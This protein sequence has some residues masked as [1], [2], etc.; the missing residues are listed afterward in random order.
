MVWP[1]ERL[2]S[3]LDSLTRWA[4]PPDSVVRRL[5]QPHVAEADVDQRLHVAGD[6]R[7]VGEELE[8]LLA[9]QVE[10]VG[11]VLVL[12]RDVE[13]VAV[14]AG[15]L[16]HLARHVDV[17]QEVH[18]DLDRAVARAGLAAAALDV[19]AEPPGQVAAHLGLVGLGE[20]LADVVEHARVG[21]RVGPGRAPD[22]RLVDVDDLV[23]LLDAVDRRCAGPAASST[24]R[25]SASATGSRMSLTSVDLPEPDTP[26]TDTK[27]PSGNS[28]SMFLR[29]C[30]RA[31]RTVSHSSPGWPA[32]RRHR[33]RP[34]ARQVLPGD[35]P[36]VAQQLA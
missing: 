11:D 35:R 10:H 2:A 16:A 28:T 31:P 3:S 4:S 19:E 20:Q 25:S 14:V 7:L 26:V 18:L 8:R 13:R 23:E 17:G 1:V 5:A 30:S 32:L 6:G 24:G 12:E 22:R 15:A 34:L 27:Q 36:A 21:G 9:A 33:D 29:L